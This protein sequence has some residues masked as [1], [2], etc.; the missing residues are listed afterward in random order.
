MINDHSHS[1]NSQWYTSKSPMNREVKYIGYLLNFDS[2]SFNCINKHQSGAVLVISLIMLL[3]LTLI[4]VTGMQTTGLEEKM[5]GN[6]RDRNL[7]FQAAES[8]LSAA[9]AS[10]S[11]TLPNFVTSGTNGYYSSAAAMP[12]IDSDTFWATGN[13]HTYSG[14]TLVGIDS[15]LQPRYIIQDLG[16]ATATCPGVHNYRITARATGGTSS[17]VVI[18]QSVFQ[19]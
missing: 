2:H 14:D 12:A 7:A 4:G 18:L 9:E 19:L 13:T 11:P 5:A 3:L 10:L 17:A 1:L 6:M 8:A 16:C 15:S